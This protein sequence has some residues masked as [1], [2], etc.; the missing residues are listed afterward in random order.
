M[1]QKPPDI[2]DAVIIDEPT[3]RFVERPSAQHTN[4]QQVT[5]LAPEQLRGDL[6]VAPSTAAPAVDPVATYLSRYVSKN[7]REAMLA[8]LRVAASLLTGTAN[9]DPR[10]VP[11]AQLRYAHVQALRAKLAEKYAEASTNRHLLA[12]RG[13]MR[14]CWQLGLID[15]DTFARIEEVPSMKLS[16]KE[17]G[18]ALSS[19]ELDALLAACD[20]SVAGRRDAAIVALAAGGGL[21]RE[22][23]CSLNLT[24]WH[25]D[26]SRLAVLGKGNKWRSVYLSAKYKGVIERWL[27]SRGRLPGALLTPI[28]KHKTVVL[29]RHLSK[30]GL[31]KLLQLVGAR[32]KV[33]DFTPH[34][35]RR[36]FMTRLLDK[37]V[38]PLT[39]SKLAGHAAVQTTMG[40]DRRAE[41]VKKQAVELLDDDD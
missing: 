16:G 38:D 5:L 29:D 21:R 17:T 24:Q 19:K 8:S 41:R 31:Y 28:S 7:S 18:R 6:Q 34:D 23:M 36:T 30:A 4:L 9:T 40:Y 11:W 37:G 33:E 13:V 10:A 32:A 14:E 15:R 12:V 22:E 2:E 3:T 26:E 27:D 35:L 39:V 20:D 1:K 25:P